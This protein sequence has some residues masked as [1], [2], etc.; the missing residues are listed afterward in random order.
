MSN[1][2]NFLQLILSNSLQIHLILSKS[3]KSPKIPTRH[4]S[5]IPTHSHSFPSPQTKRKFHIPHQTTKDTKY[6]KQPR[7]KQQPVTNLI[8]VIFSP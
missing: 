3:L 1:I 5:L 8:I 2:R 6:I 4:I 7:E